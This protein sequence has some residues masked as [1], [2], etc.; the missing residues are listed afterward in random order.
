MLLG[1]FKTKRQKVTL[2]DRRVLKIQNR[3]KIVKHFIIPA[4]NFETFLLF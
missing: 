3:N 1:F 4:S 2:F